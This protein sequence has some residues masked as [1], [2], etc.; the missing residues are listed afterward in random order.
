[1]VAFVLASLSE[2]EEFR[3]LYAGMVF[4]KAA[5]FTNSEVMINYN[6]V[7]L[8]SEFDWSK[9]GAVSSVK[10]Q[11]PCGS[12]WAFSALGNV[13]G[14]WFRRTGKLISLSAQQL[15]DC[16]R[17]DHGCQGGLMDQA[18][19]AIKSMG[20]IQS[21]ESYPYHARRGQCH[22][23]RKKIVA[24]V[25]ESLR[26]PEN[27]YLLAEWL[28]SNGPISVGINADMLQFY[29]G[30]VLRPSSRICPATQIDHGV[31]LVGFGT[32]AKGPFWIV[33]NSWGVDWGEKGYFRIGRN[34][35]ACGINVYAVS[36]VIK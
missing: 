18:F 2:D 26:L 22:L 23:D 11:G 28:H 14:Q 7:S 36:S 6:P 32:E 12:C 10:D 1:M 16:D 33:K 5:P 13:E 34:T 25:N 24:Y 4:E 17:K 15:V 29:R 35:G 19:R 21:D 31:L 30:G 20:G 9:L 3:R 8:P 27:E